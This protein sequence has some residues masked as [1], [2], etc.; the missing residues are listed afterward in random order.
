MSAVPRR[1][2]LWSAADS[3]GAFRIT[4]EDFT[5]GRAQLTTDNQQ[6]TTLSAQVG[7]RRVTPDDM[8]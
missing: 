7:Y 6:L 3:N 4:W 8:A 2:R 5:L 1:S